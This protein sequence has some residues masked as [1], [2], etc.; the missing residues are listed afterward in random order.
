MNFR[1]LL[2]RLT[3]VSRD[4]EKFQ[5]FLGFA[6]QVA[7]TNPVTLV[8]LARRYLRLLPL[9]PEI[10]KAMAGGSFDPD[11]AG[12]LASDYTTHEIG[13]VINSGG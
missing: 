9:L 4:Q 8:D 13:M 7:E 1:R 6:R 2:T 10:V 3:R 12:K 11:A 5:H